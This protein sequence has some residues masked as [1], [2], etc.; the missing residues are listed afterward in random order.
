M[1]KLCQCESD[2]Y[3]ATQDDIEYK[4]RD[5]WLKYMIF[6]A[7]AYYK[8]YP[9]NLNEIGANEGYH[10]SEWMY[11]CDYCG[12]SIY[13]DSEAYDR[14]E[15]ARRHP[16]TEEGYYHEEMELWMGDCPRKILLTPEAADWAWNECSLDDMKEGVD[17][18][19]ADQDDD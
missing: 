19:Y 5:E 16:F 11:T 9:D 12:A 17:Y 3:P 18:R 14:I 13:N 6:E 8:C 2:T 7:S 1:T 4:N 15:A 10:V